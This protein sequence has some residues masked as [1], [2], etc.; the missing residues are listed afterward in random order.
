MAA[1]KG[2]VVCAGR[3]EGDQAVDQIARQ[4]V[5]GAAGNRW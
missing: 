2:V 4:K 5:F 3:D 1:G